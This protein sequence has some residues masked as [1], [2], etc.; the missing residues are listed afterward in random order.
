MGRKGLFTSAAAGGSLIAAS[1]V[2]VIG[3]SALI[4]FRGF[5]SAREVPAQQSVVL[6]SVESGAV[7][8]GTAARPAAVVIGGSDRPARSSSRR[9]GT[10]RRVK[11]RARGAAPARRRASIPAREG[12]SAP[13]A[14]NPAAAPGGDAQPSAPQSAPAGSPVAPEEKAP[15]AVAAPVED[16]VEDVTSVVGET[17][18]K[19]AEKPVESVGDALL[20][21]RDALP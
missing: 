9:R 2:L 7:E 3:V 17:V 6:R 16:A 14:G 8:P 20:D 5:R 19:T 12:I 11:T 18:P 13:A 4:G 15:P 21:L 10:G 1:L